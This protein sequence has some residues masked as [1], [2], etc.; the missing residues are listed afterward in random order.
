MIFAGLK[1]LKI[2]GGSPCESSLKILYFFLNYWSIVDLQCHVSF[3][4]TAKWISYTHLRTFQKQVINIKNCSFI[5]EK[6]GQHHIMKTVQEAK[7][8]RLGEGGEPV[9]E[10]SVAWRGTHRLKCVEEAVTGEEMQAKSD[11][12]V[13]RK[14][15]VEGRVSWCVFLMMKKKVHKKASR[16]WT[17][18]NLA[19]SYGVMTELPKLSLLLWSS[20]KTH[21]LNVASEKMSQRGVVTVSRWRLRNQPKIW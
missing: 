11:N 6:S 2:E 13:C 15:T 21:C 20:L 10:I 7:K 18:K 19:G 9:R 5:K 1:I 14:L 3:C 4:C 12:L 16:D 17:S 8:K